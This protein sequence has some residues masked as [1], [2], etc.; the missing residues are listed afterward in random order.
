[1]KMIKNLKNLKPSM[2]GIK[3]ISRIS[4][5]ALL[6]GGIMVGAAHNWLNKHAVKSLAP[7]TVGYGKRGIDSNNLN[8]EGLVQGLSNKRR[9]K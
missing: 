5:T 6:G 8:T 3:Q 2:S 7:G 1:M 9:A 4:G